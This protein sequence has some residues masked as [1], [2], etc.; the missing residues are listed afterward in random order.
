[1]L[2]PGD[3]VVIPEK[4]IKEE[5]AATEKLHKFKRKGVPAML[6]IRLLRNGQPRA[7]FGWSANLGGKWQEGKTD[8][9]GM[10]QIKL[11]PRCEGGLLKLEDGMEYQL[12]L[13]EL[14]PVETVS[15]VQGRLNNLGYE[16]GPVDGKVSE[17]SAEAI[18]QFQSDYPP[19]KVDGMVSDEFCAKLK[20]IYGC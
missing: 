17:T 14:D 2:L 8:G 18:K 3:V 16:A 19:L 12:L 11:E 10:V 9:D 1:M 13:R 4:K 5:S 7:N 6:K 20:E 15:G